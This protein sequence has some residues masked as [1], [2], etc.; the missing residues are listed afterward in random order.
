[1]RVSGTFFKE[2]ALMS[3]GRK[4]EKSGP[5]PSSIQK[6]KMA[7]AKTGKVVL[8]KKMETIV[9]EITRLNKSVTSKKKISSFSELPSQ[10]NRIDSL[11]FEEIQDSTELLRI[12]NNIRH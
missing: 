10:L 5:N 8:K 7:Q 12:R 6:A 9:S 1:M 4:K 11:S 2:T 3:I